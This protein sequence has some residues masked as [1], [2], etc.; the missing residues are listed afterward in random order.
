MREKDIRFSVIFFFFFLL[1][2]TIAYN[3]FLSFLKLQWLTSLA[4]FFLP[5]HALTEEMKNWAFFVF[6]FYCSKRRFAKL[7]PFEIYFPLQ[8]TQIVLY[9]CYFG[10]YKIHLYYYFYF[11]F[12]YWFRSDFFRDILLSLH[13]C[14]RS[15]GNKFFYVESIEIISELTKKLKLFLYQ[16]EYNFISSFIEFDQILKNMLEIIF[17]Y[18]RIDKQF[19]HIILC[20]SDEISSD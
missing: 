17:Q 7:Y 11:L 4:S 3:F 18:C 16:I 6:V 13:I 8:I 9:R 1:F 5:P 14:V 19:I 2:I 15:K 12:L 20:Y 10:N